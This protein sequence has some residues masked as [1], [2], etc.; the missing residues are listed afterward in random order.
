MIDT[1]NHCTCDECPTKCEHR[2][3]DG[4]AK[5]PPTWWTVLPPKLIHGNQPAHLCSN[6]CMQRWTS[7][8]A[9]L[10]QGVEI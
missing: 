2:S 6:V 1:L 4:T 10:P 7:R 5:P 9:A 8:F 3:E